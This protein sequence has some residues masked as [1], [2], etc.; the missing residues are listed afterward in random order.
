[1]E[2]QFTGAYDH[3]RCCLGNVMAILN[4]LSLLVCSSLL[5]TN[6]FDRD[7]QYSGPHVEHSKMSNCPV[8]MH[9]T[10]AAAALL[11]VTNCP[12]VSLLYC[13]VTS[14]TCPLHTAGFICD[15]EANGHGP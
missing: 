1:M 12:A 10:A 7:L 11:A 5:R 6:L 14:V 15:A 9:L 4:S 3:K 8:K 13:V 2:L